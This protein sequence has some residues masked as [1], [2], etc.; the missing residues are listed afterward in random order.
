M[1]PIGR[2]C[3]DRPL[4][5]L[6]HVGFFANTVVFRA[7]LGGDHRLRS[8]TASGAMRSSL[9]P[10]GTLRPDREAPRPRRLT[11]S[12]VQALAHQ[13]QPDVLFSLPGIETVPCRRNGTAKFEILLERRS[14]PHVDCLL[15]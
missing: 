4:P 7:D 5:E 1:I 2:A 9:F 12:A 8:M 15:G 6:E 3:G 14:E 11:Q 13:Q 10:P